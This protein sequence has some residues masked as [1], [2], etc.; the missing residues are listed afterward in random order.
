[1]SCCM[2]AECQGMYGSSDEFAQ[3]VQHAFMGMCEFGVGSMA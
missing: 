2:L 3:Q 1:M